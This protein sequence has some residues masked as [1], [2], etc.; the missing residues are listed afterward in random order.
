MEIDLKKVMS[1]D[2]Y[3]TLDIDEDASDS[4]VSNS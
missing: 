3:K 4:D 1:L 2:L